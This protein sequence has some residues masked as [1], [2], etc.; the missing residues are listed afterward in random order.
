MYLDARLH[1]ALHLKAK[2]NDSTISEVVSDALRHV[3]SLEARA[4]EGVEARRPERK[5]SLASVGARLKR[6]GKT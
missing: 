5:M 4:I 1:R 2:A 3:L 6:R